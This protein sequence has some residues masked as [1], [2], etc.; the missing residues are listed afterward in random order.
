MLHS[1]GFLLEYEC[2]ELRSGN[3]VATCKTE[4]IVNSG[5]LTNHIQIAGGL[6]FVI[7]LLAWYATV[8]IMAK[9]MNFPVRLP[10][11]DLSRFWYQ[12]NMDPER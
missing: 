12:T 3:D 1:F 8:A 7:G 4:S 9:E 5:P 11:G 2:C 10:L 6:L